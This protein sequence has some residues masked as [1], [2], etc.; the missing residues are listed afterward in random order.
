MVDT[1][2]IGELIVFEE[3]KWTGDETRSYDAVNT[4]PENRIEEMMNMMRA[5][6]TTVENINS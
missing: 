1:E 2:S 3:R 6:M 4:A 5:V